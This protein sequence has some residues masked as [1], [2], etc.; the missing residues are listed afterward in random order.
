MS[1]IGS[2]S[3]QIPVRTASAQGAD[4]DQTL[5]FDEDT[6]ALVPSA[7]TPSDAEP[8]LIQSLGEEWAVLPL[9]GTHTSKARTPTAP[10]L[11]PSR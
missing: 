10:S 5:V 1:L 2:S 11:R 4:T 6:G 3:I 7:R 9:G 8:L